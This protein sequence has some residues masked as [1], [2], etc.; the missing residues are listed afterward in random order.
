MK[1]K[2][3][4]KALKPFGVVLIL[5]LSVLFLIAC[6]TMDMG[7]P[8]RYTPAHAA[9]YY[10][11]SLQNMEELKQ[12]LEENVF[13]QIGVIE[14]SYVSSSGTELVIITQKGGAD[15]AAAVLERDFDMSLF[16]IREEE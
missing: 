2:V 5:V 12:E 3:D 1:M 4:L 14:D 6:F 7:V 9:E 10:K 15:K 16:D 13:P 8:E 11:E